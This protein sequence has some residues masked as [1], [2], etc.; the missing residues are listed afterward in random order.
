MCVPVSVCVLDVSKNVPK[1]NNHHCRQKFENCVT[2]VKHCR[3]GQG[4]V[5]DYYLCAPRQLVK[6]KSKVS[7]FRKLSS[8]SWLNQW[9]HLKIFTACVILKHPPFSE[10]PGLTCGGWSLFCCDA[11]MLLISFRSQSL[12]SFRLPL[13]FHCN[14]PVLW[15]LDNLSWL[16]IAR[17]AQA[18]PL[19]ALC[20]LW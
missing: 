1:L 5:K 16:S 14:Q 2:S 11:C 12:T 7:S 4:K 10:H 9:D 17:S 19:F 15:L 20:N 13:T 6:V 3:R 8:G 18:K